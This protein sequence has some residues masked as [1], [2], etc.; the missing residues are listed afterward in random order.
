MNKLRMDINDV[1]TVKLTDYGR[2]ILKNKYEYFKRNYT[3]I[4]LPL[5]ESIVKNGMYK[6]QLWLV[7]KDFGNFIDAGGE[8]PIEYIEVKIPNKENN[9]DIN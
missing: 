7:I 5:F 2:E 6:A 1:V 9:N 4:R 3:D 8:K